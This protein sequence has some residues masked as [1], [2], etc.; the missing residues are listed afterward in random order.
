MI[1]PSTWQGQ[2]SRCWSLLRGPLAIDLWL[3]I[4]DRP[5]R[6]LSIEG[7]QPRIVYVPVTRDRA[8]AILDGLGRERS[9]GR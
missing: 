5:M 2:G 1:P 8:A 6:Y 9:Q 3:D 7:V 4:N